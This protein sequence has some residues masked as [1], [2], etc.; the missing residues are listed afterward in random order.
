MKMVTNMIDITTCLPCKNRCSYCPQ[1]ILMKHYK[2]IKILTLKKFDEVL[3][4]I[5]KSVELLFCGLGEPFQNPECADMILL[6][7]SKGHKIRVF[8]TLVGLTDKDAKKIKDIPFTRFFV[9]ELLN[10]PDSHR[11]FSFVTERMTEVELKHFLTSRAGNLYPVPRKP[12]VSG[13]NPCS[14]GVM[15]PNGDFYICGMDW[16][17]KHK[18]GNLFKTNLKDIKKKEIYELCYYCEYAKID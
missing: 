18:M 9:H 14:D 10:F 1:D 3:K 13:C 11:K 4:N 17:L 7:H 15:L 5:P 8:T 2:G 6:A 16:A 12:F